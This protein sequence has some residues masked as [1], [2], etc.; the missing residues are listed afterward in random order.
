LKINLITPADRRSR[1]GNRTTAVR[2]AG[3]LR[4]LGHRVAVATAYDGKAGDMM[5]ALHAW[6]SADAIERFAREQ[7]GKPLVVALTGTDIHRFQFSHPGPTLRSMELAHVLVTL[8]DRVAPEIPERFAKKIV[9]IYQSARP[10]PRRLPPVKRYFDVCV[11]GHLREEKDPLRAALA[12]RRLPPESAIRVTQLGKAIDKEWERAAKAEMKTN[13]RYRWL[14][15][16][17]G[18]TVR[19]AL[20]RVRLMV[21]S[22]IME[23]GANVVSEAVV[24]GVPVLASAIPGNIGLLGEDY[25]GYF[26]VKDDRALAELLWKAEREPAFLAL[27]ARHCLWRAPLFSPAH[28][29][30]SW[31]RLMLKLS[32]Q[33]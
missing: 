24:A 10:L 31:R 15:E 17:P 30:K 6:R 26:P 23:G 14:G 29:L 22:S 19:K 16:V 20:Q 3:I 18:S 7:P 5:I 4:E 21:I 1:A 33:G 12:A 11:I 25:P 32:L 2:W 13:P 27:L 28:E 8:H 9:T